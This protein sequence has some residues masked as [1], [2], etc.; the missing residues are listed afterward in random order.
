MYFDFY[1]YQYIIVT[2]FTCNIQ[3]LKKTVHSSI[4]YRKD[5]VV[6]CSDRIL[7]SLILN[8]S[9][10]CKIFILFNIVLYCKK[11]FFLLLSRKKKSSSIEK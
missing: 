6:F 11:H 2:L 8:I 9:R 10:K 4:R 7:A 5:G 3:A 1:V